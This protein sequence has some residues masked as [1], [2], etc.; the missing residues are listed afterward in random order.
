MMIRADGRKSNELRK[1]EIIPDF[2][3]YAEGSA[4]IKMGDTHIICTASVEEKV[5]EFLHG[6]GQ[7]WI[8]AEYEM[9]PRATQTRIRRER[10]RGIKG[11]SSEIQRL[12]GRSLRAISDLTVL[13]ER[14]VKLDCDVIQ[15]D[16]GTRVS[17][18]NGAFVALCIAADKLV[19]DNVIEKSFIKD[20]VSAVSLG[21]LNGNIIVDPCYEEDSIADV[22][23]NIVMRGNMEFI[24]IQG[25]AEHQSFD[26]EQLNILLDTAIEPIKKIREI[27]LSVLKERNVIILGNSM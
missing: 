24:E 8:T 20:S 19:Q 6:T 23:F 26:R 7:G 22:D 11:R 10:E 3:K 27:Q 2:N 9:I 13:G 25:T 16:G 1:I 18:I 15:A 4:L 17:S 5:P 21:L 12:I 14:T